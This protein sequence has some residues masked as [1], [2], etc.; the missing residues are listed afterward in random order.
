MRPRHY[1]P[2]AFALVDELD[3]RHPWRRDALCREYGTA[4]FFPERG[5]VA[6]AQHA[7]EVCV[8]CPVSAE[9]RTYAAT[10]ELGRM[11]LPGIWGGTSGLD[12]RRTQ[13]RAA[14]ASARRRLRTAAPA[15]RASVR[16]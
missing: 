9:C 6:E 11:R 7:R 1:P 10:I 15:T 16:G 13:N 14:R 4:M 3:D 12:R 8:R 2:A 5:E